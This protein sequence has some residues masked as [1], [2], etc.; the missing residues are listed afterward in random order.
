MSVRRVQLAQIAEL[1]VSRVCLLV[2]ALPIGL[3]APVMSSTDVSKS[4]KVMFDVVAAQHLC[5]SLC[6]NVTL[7]L[8]GSVCACMRSVSCKAQP[9][10]LAAV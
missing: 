4:S 6:C 5:Q 9:C 10:T 7:L 2:A 1:A 3:Q 8:P